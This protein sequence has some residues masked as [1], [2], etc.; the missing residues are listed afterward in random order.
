MEKME[1][2]KR[3]KELQTKR[4]EVF[5]KLQND[6]SNPYWYEDWGR[7]IDDYDKQIAALKEKLGEA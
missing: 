3:L 5:K 4:D 7:I 2:E 1:T 6:K